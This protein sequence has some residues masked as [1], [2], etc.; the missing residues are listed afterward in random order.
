MLWPD[1]LTWP[2]AVALFG[3]FMIVGTLAR[4]GD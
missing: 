2:L 4:R 1:W 3:L